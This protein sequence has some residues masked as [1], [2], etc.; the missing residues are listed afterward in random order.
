MHILLN[1]DMYPRNS[2]SAIAL[3]FVSL[4]I[5]VG[6]SS[7][8]D[9]SN[10]LTK[11]D[12]IVFPD[13]NISYVRHVQPLFDLACATAGC[14][15][16]ATAENKELDLTSYA[17]VVANFGVVVAGD[18]SNS[19]MVWSIEGRPGSAPMPPAKPLN[20]NQIKGIKRWIFEGAKDTP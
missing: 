7:C 17:G 16:R 20:Q 13:S 14:H 6:V 4:I 2:D 5:F 15:D 11:V 1:N 18:T 9:T 3:I 10:P 8:R 19:R 12:D